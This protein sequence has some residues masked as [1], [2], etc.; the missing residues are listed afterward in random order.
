MPRTTA[1]LVFLLL[2][3]GSLTAKTAVFVAQSAAKSEVTDNVSTFLTARGFLLSH[4]PPRSAP[5]WIIGTRGACRVRIAD[6]AA[7]GWTRT[8]AAEQATDDRLL[9]AFDGRFYAKQPVW[10]TRLEK[11]RR[12]LL[13]YF[14]V[15]QPPLAVRVLTVSK[16]CP[17]D[18]IRPTDAA[19]LSR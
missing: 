10:R 8:I 5:A 2:I 12:R 6:V 4:A 19:L 7:E 14:G 15:S 17:A 9:F 3:A 18:T 13:R 11:Y 16:G 1:S